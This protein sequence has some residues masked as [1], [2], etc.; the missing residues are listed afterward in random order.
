MTSLESRADEFRWSVPESITH[1]Y[2]APVYQTLTEKERRVYNKLHACFCCEMLIFFEEELPQGYSTAARG[3][4]VSKSVYG[5]VQAM[6]ASESRHAAMFRDLARD[7]DSNL[8]EPFVYHFLRMPKGIL[9]LLKLPL[10]YPRL[11]PLVFW[12][13]LLQEERAVYYSKEVIRCASELDPRVVDAFSRHMDDEKDHLGVDEALLEVYW[14]RSSSSIRWLN[15]QAFRILV[16]EF[17]NAPKR[18]GIR[19]IERLVQEVPTL[20]G[21]K[22]ELTAGLLDLAKDARFHES[23]YS[24]KIVPKTFALFDRYAEFRSLGD[25][26]RGY[27]PGGAA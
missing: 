24:R 13:V 9:R 22:R 4:G 2:Y 14:E 17:L 25:R 15:A 18:G 26:V 23:L 21:R 20:E 7:L 12:I 10:Q 11:F 5:E 27:S 1:L 19:V 6:L 8:Y 3:A 16:D